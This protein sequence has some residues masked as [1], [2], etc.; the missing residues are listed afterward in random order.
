MKEKDDLIKQLENDK[1]E[2]A[3]QLEKEQKVCLFKLS[4]C[5]MHIGLQSMREC[6]FL[7]CMS[8]AVILIATIV[9]FI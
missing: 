2:L 4:E 8:V 6:Y 9:A 5:Y 3:A 7:Y 1:R